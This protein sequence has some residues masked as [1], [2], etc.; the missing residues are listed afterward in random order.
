MYGC[1]YLCYI[2]Y[3]LTGS[4][5]LV[6][7]SV[8][9]FDEDRVDAV[10]AGIHGGDIRGDGNFERNRGARGDVSFGRGEN[11]GELAN[12][13]SERRDDRRRPTRAAE[14][15]GD[16][17]K[18]QRELVPDAEKACLLI[19]SQTSQEFVSRSPV[20]VSRRCIVVVY[21][22]VVVQGVDVD[23]SGGWG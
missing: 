17:T 6:D 19:N 18:V 14:V 20:G 9:L 10:R 8:G 4:Q 11:V 3:I 16:V 22:N 12:N 7:H 23:N 1:A 21:R 2:F 15:K 5:I 13:F